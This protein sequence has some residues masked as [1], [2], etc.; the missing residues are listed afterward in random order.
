MIF[1]RILLLLAAGILFSCDIDRYIGH[2]LDAQNLLETTTVTGTVTN[3][4]T[5]DS[6]YGAEIRLGNAETV[7]DINGKYSIK[8]VLTQDELRNKPLEISIEAHNYF[9]QKDTVLLEPVMNIFNY[10]LEYAAPIIRNVARN[11]TILEYG[12]EWIKYQI[13]VQAIVT[14]YQGAANISDASASFFFSGGADSLKVPLIVK[15][16]PNDFTIYYQAVYVGMITFDLNYSVSTFDFDGYSDLFEASNNPFKMD[17]ELLFD[18][19][20]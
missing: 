2:D 10:E 8:Y 18:S 14:D 6:V 19:G 17:E 1:R 11:I 15:D 16:R 9:P 7:T 4:F 3:F 13:I 20:L 12:K 5:S